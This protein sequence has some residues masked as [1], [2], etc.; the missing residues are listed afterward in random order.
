M[1]PSSDV[2][3]TTPSSLPQFTAHHPSSQFARRAPPRGPLTGGA[4]LLVRSLRV[5]GG[6]TRRARRGCPAPPALLTRVRAANHHLHVGRE[7][8]LARNDARRRRR[9]WASRGRWAR[10]LQPRGLPHRHRGARAVVGNGGRGLAL[11][12][13][14]ARRRGDLWRGLVASWRSRRV[15]RQRVMPPLGRPWL[16]RS[17]PLLRLHRRCC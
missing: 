15:G 8:A 11:A 13:L 17:R 4:D 2:D 7:A 3:V 5:V 14:L 10:G 16:L 9:G 1:M 6:S 12:L